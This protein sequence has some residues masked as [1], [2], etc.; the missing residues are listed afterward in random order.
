MKVL[1]TSG[2]T[3]VPIDSVRYISNMAT[4]KFGLKLAD[5]FCTRGNQVTV[6]HSRN[7]ADHRKHTSRLPDR[8]IVNYSTYWDYHDTL[9][10]LLAREKYDLVIS[11]AAVSD[12][13]VVDQ[14][15]SKISGDSEVIIK[16]RPVPK[17]LPEIK[18][19]QP[20]C[21]LI[22]F[23]LL[24]GA[25]E[26]EMNAAVQKQ[27]ENAH[28]DIVAFNDLR[29]KYKAYTLFG[30]DGYRRVVIA[31]AKFFVKHSLSMLGI[32]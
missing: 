19:M 25:S 32:K 4:G 11:A 24:V 9:I 2:G 1:I 5:E 31:D 14:G 8:S 23:K 16:L 7:G 22:G 18:K 12:Y 26:E 30:K 29:S 6:L 10:A 21:K 3:T 17:V 13:E 27:F 28:S 15:C 20:D